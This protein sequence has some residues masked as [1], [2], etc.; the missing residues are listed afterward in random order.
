MQPPHFRGDLLYQST[1]GAGR[2]LGS[3][4]PV[5]GLQGTGE[6]LPLFDQ[7]IRRQGCSTAVVAISESTA[8]VTRTARAAGGAESRVSAGGPTH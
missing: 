7:A 8:G 3:S 6:Y 5:I 2:I 1:M 4:A